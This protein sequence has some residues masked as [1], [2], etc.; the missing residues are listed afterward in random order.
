MIRGE[1]LAFSK[2]LT[3]FYLVAVLGFFLV[4][5]VFVVVVVVV[6]VLLLLLLLLVYC[7]PFFSI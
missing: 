3:S 7:F 6:V 1:S 2:G 4:G 5:V